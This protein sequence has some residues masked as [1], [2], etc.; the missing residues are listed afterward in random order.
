MP[1]IAGTRVRCAAC[2]SEAI[3]LKSESP[4]LSCCES[5]VEE[6]FTPDQPSAPGS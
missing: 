3:V 1:T 2:G 5:P 4:Q 6:T